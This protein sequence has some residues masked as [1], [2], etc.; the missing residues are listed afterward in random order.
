MS[1]NPPQSQWPKP[2]LLQVLEAAVKQGCIRLDFRAEFGPEAEQMARSFQGAINRIRRRSDAQHRSFIIPEYHL[3][4][5]TWEAGRGTM[6]LT[7]SSLPDDMKLPKIEAVSE[8]EKQHLT[9]PELI[10]APPEPLAS[11]GAQAPAV[12]D[13]AGLIDELLASQGKGGKPS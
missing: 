4:T 5:T 13:P 11:E 9:R 6:L 8:D 3:V 2:Y 12:F 1:T 7:Y 10:E